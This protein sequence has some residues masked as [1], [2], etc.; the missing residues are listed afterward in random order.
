MWKNNQRH[1]YGSFQYNEGT[2]F[3][4]NRPLTAI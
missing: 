2:V 1:G 4:G 3:E